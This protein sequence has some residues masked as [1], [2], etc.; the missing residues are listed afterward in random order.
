MYRAFELH[1]DK[2]IL[3]KDCFRKCAT[4]WSNKITSEKSEIK[5]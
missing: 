5:G 3:D 1:M 2:N 4:V